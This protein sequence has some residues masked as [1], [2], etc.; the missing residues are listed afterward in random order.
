MAINRVNRLSNFRADDRIKNS[1]G[2]DDVK[3]D[4]NVD[5][6][7]RQGGE[8]SVTLVAID[9]FHRRAPEIV[10]EHAAPR[11]LT[12]HIPVSHHR[13]YVVVHKVAIERVQIT[14][15]RDERDRH[16]DAPAR[17]L[18]RLSPVA[19]GA[20]VP[21]GRLAEA[22]GAYVVTSSHVAWH[23]LRHHARDE[24]FSRTSADLTR[25]FTRMKPRPCLFGAPLSAAPLIAPGMTAL[26]ALVIS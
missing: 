10:V 12:D 11:R 15:D 4:D 5:L 3:G 13:R 9:A 6:P 24:L 25:A 26:I 2:T 22:R 16:V 21:L 18:V 1:R 17:W 20:S 8:R 19:T 7:E 14:T 23:S